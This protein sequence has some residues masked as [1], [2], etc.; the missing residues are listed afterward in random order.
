MDGALIERLTEASPA[1]VRRRIAERW[2]GAVV[3]APARLG[4]VTLRPHQ[5][6]AL[7]R[8]RAAIAELGGALLADEVG[9]GK[10]YVALALATEYPT[11]LVVAPAALRGMWRSAL[12]D[13]GVRA[14]I[15][16]HESLS[17]G[18]EPAGNHALVIVDEAH[19]ARNPAT[20]RWSAL[21]RLTRDARVLLL[22]ATPVHNRRDD[23]VA[24][25][26]LFLGARARAL[27]EATLARCI[28]RREQA[29]LAAAA[30]LPRVEP[31]VTLR[32]GGV[33]V[34]R[35]ILALPAPVPPADGG[36][37]GALLAHGLVRQWASSE[38]ALR[39]ALRRRLVQGAALA[40][41]LETGS[42]PTR[43]EL[44]AWCVG[45]EAVQL[46]LPGLGAA[47][48][49]GEAQ[50]AAM[51]HAVRAHEHALR[52][53][54]R[55]LDA[56]PSADV[57]RAAR[58]RELRARHAGERV[59]AFAQYADTI[60]ALWRLLRADGGVCALTA[61]GARVAGGVLS[62][63]EAL[64][65]V[66]PLANGAREPPEAERVTLLLTTDLLSE[67]VNLQDASVV[68]HLDLPWTAARLEQRVGRVARLGSRHA[69]VAVYALAPPAS[70]E[71]LL[72][73][74]RRLREKLAA[75]GRTVGVA[76]TILPPLTATS[77]HIHD[78]EPSPAAR[79][80]EVRSAMERWLREPA[81]STEGDGPVVAA[82][83]GVEAGA[84]AL[85][86]VGGEPV[87][88]AAAGACG[89]LTDDPA[90][91]ARL[92]PAL[93]APSVPLDVALGARLMALIE[94]WR[95]R[96][97]LAADAGLRE[98]PV[99][100]ARRRLVRRIAAITHRAPAHA[101]PAIA[102]LAD[103]ARR[104][105]TSTLGAGAERVLDE[106]AAAPLD[107]EAW[108]RAVGAFAALHARG[109]ASDAAN[110][111]PR[112]VAAVLVAHA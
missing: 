12:A 94:A 34:L 31:P 10:T 37:G 41:A 92:L 73:A 108:L 6:A 100:R 48:A 93:E 24:L 85:L 90:I 84:L 78:V 26:A 15:T 39:G 57:E 69:R 88:L 11:V 19:H 63:A 23:L 3:A 67:G 49:A 82:V 95:S 77:A 60:G 9:L 86:E 80:E 72:A 27:D 107:D 42:R 83:R 8:L 30:E 71:A 96:R 58:L 112:L 28:V 62:R 55:R 35:E 91:V 76:G 25:L 104:A 81:E 45:D 97:E 59:V 14:A 54:L 103:G 110:A 50:A 87:L 20:R 32:V 52:A 109:R 101:R 33:D 105:A 106:L 66:A 4:R 1:E 47:P 44:A 43:R 68:V 64:R 16:S 7:A 89:A 61:G 98:L 18:R 70:A 75:A 56:G 102:A 36:D 17:R 13:C 5:A 2:L 79:A 40:A 51:L 38:G 21:A 99:A 65:R 74:E 46:A 29:T 22:S 111:A 53:L